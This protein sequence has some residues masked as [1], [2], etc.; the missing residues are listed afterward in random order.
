QA[1]VAV[2]LALTVAM[3]LVAHCV[4]HFAGLN[5]DVLGAAVEVTVTVCA[6]GTSCL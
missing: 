3:A 6:V 1:P 5:G 4:R 2:L